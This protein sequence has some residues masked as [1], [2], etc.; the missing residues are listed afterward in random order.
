MRGTPP[1]ERFLLQQT[2]LDQHLDVFFLWFGGAVC[3]IFPI[4]GACSWGDLSFFPLPDLLFFPCAL[5]DPPFIVL[6]TSVFTRIRSGAAGVV[7][8]GGGIDRS[9]EAAAEVVGR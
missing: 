4:F 7:D 1:G 5:E 8:G 9:L 3:L 2:S 6:V